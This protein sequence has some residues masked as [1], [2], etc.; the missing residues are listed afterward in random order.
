MKPIDERIKDC[1][2]AVQEFQL[3]DDFREWWRKNQAELV[4]RGRK[5]G[6]LGAENVRLKD[7]KVDGLQSEVERL[8]GIIDR[9]HKHAIRHWVKKDQFYHMVEFI[10]IVD[11]AKAEGREED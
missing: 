5:I 11:E 6:D 7:T 2:V 1:L 8:R 10:A 3:A 9:L 4:R